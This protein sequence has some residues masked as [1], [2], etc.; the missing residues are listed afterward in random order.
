MVST[1]SEP[2]GTA[3]HARTLVTGGCG[4]IGSHFIRRYLAA[5]PEGEVVNLDLLTYA[6]NP[7]NLADVAGDPRY[8][9][10]HADVN[11]AAAVQRALAGC[12]T[13]VH[14]AAESH[15][16]RS[17]LDAIPFIR[18]NV[19]GTA[20]LL[21]AAHEAGVRRFLH[22]ST[23][24]VYGD[25]PAPRVSD[26]QDCLLPRSPYAA[27]KAAAEMLCRAY[28]E[29]YRLPLIVA[30]C[31]NVYGPNQFPEKLI[32]LFVTNAISGQPVP[33]YGDGQQQRDWTYVDDACAAFDFLLERG[34]PG[35]NYNVT[36]E[37]VRRNIDVVQAL[38]AA[39]DRPASLIRFVRD[40]P[41]HDARYAM[42]A[43]K[44]RALGWKPAHAWADAFP[45]TVR[46][47][48]EHPTWWQQAR[49]QAFDAYYERQYSARA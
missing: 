35:E 4:F 17:L 32:P 28:I 38:L 2:S 24:E 7:D 3:P 8:H 13:V 46:W 14:F 44:L 33:V 9:F 18:T 27:S 29:T 22:I 25:V 26:E 20:T 11:D 5:H 23:D 43:A 10:V 45:R 36:A 1:S 34:R 39:L 12:D 48:A 21:A 47:Y 37:N 40:R 16:D 31:S 41:G 42:S 6:G 30:R 49:N 19:E 15:V